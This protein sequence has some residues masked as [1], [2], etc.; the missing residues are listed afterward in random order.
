MK[1]QAY[2]KV[3]CDYG[4]WAYRRV[5]VL[6]LCKRVNLY[7]RTTEYQKVRSFILGFIPY[8]RWVNKMCIVWFDEEAVEYYDC[9]C[10]PSE[11]ND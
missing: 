9:D 2:E 8:T 3:V 5:E 4:G 1:K 11:H 10:G 6:P 7:G